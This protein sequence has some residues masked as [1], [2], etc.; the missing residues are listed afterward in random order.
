MNLSLDATVLGHNPD[1]VTVLTPQGTVLHWNR[2][3]ESIF[4]YSADEAI[5]ESFTDL[6]VA[7][8]R[9]GQ[10]QTLL[11]DA[12]RDG[13]SV[14]EAVRH[15]KDG[16]SLYVSG[17]AK[18]VTDADGKPQCF[19]VTTKDVTR[20][21]L[22]RHTQLVEARYRDL[23]EDTPD[24][25]LIVNITGLI[26][27]ANAQALHLFGH[28]HE[29]LI[30]QP[31]ELLMPE[32][33]R[34]AHLGH[35]G[36]YFDLPRK[37]SMGAGLELHGQRSDGREFPVEISLSPLQ[38]EEGLLVMCALRDIT[39]REEARN[40]A[41]RKFR[42]LLESAPDAMVIVDGQGLI[43]LV[44]SQAVRLFGWA[45]D[46]LLGQP[47]ETLV[48]PRYRGDHFK[49][50]NGFFD[51][52]KMRRMGAGLE[53]QGLRR[54]GSEFPVEIS[55]SPIETEDGLLV[56]SA[57]RDASD[58]K[59]IEHKL[60]EAN[61]LKSEFLASMSH[62]L[63]TPLNGILGFSELLVDQRIG[64]LNQK[65]IEYI[66]DIHQCGRHLLQ[67]INDVLDLSKV[68]AGKMEAY[69]ETF[70]M[71]ATIASVCAVV[72]PIARKKHILV[73]TDVPAA[74][75]PVTLDAQK[76][77]QILFN[78]LSNAIKFTE[79]NGQVTLEL[80]LDGEAG[81][82]IRVID[83]GIGITA[84]DQARLFG[85]FV[86]LDSGASRRH[87]GTGLGLALTRKLVEL[88]GGRITVQSEPGKGSVF[89]VW[90]PRAL[91]SR[92]A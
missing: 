71:L 31:V 82:R 12:E 66:T 50:R 74:M 9:V 58:R 88:Q 10:F 5:G 17:S 37:R 22:I 69:A 55:L 6:V 46:E 18:A 65:Q 48:P 85:A 90:L 1:A 44:N 80:E 56:A 54:D 26:V 32:R 38:T 78:L 64:P 43:V 52:P 34:R 13:Q 53:L 14:D 79:D 7:P 42:G 16:S 72:A 23:L 47:I 33:Y 63:R 30:G 4:G 73:G 89:S 11:S 20:L 57:I 39:D 68:E 3:A 2:A 76:V 28:A 60:E 15:R 67:L 59:R 36:R 41:D 81:V 87:D 62:E 77:K 40:K 75:P 49:S 19:V 21:K 92:S 29:T 83:T 61:R 27:L 84:A 24:A 51:R 45:R 86:Q 25:I 91:P 70:D 8:D 35:R